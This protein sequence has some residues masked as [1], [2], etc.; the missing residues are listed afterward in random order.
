MLFIR[1]IAGLGTFGLTLLFLRWEGHK[2]GDI[3]ALPD[4]RSLL[5]LA[6]GLFIG[7]VLVGLQTLIMWTAGHVHWLPASEVTFPEMIFTLVAYLAL[8]AREELVFHGYP[9]R[10]L[11]SQFG[12]W[13]AQLSVA[14][15]FTLEHMAG[16]SSWEDAVFGAGV[17]SLLYGMA[18]IATRG[19]ALPIGLH[20]AWNY[21]YWMRGTRGSGRFWKPIVEDGFEAR[22]QFVGMIG[23]VPVIGLATLSF[24]CWH[25]ST[26]RSNARRG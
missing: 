5:R 10:R 14:F 19:L 3:G 17:G 20:A 25:R 24:W 16:G 2:L 1:A 26:E 21:G 18:A 4:R 15:V 12:L 8:S 6:F 22:S 9:L 13:G 7:L 23:Y 11:Y